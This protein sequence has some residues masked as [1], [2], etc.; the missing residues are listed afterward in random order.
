VSN[1]VTG[2]RYAYRPY[3]Y[4]QL[5]FSSPFS[6]IM[7]PFVAGVILGAVDAAQFPP[8]PHVVPGGY[9]VMGQ[10]GREHH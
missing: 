5:S 3:S 8:N 2:F 7:T 4:D 10:L 6:Y 1:S 9:R